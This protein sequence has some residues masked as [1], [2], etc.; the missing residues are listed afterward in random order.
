M[1]VANTKRD[2]ETMTL[3]IGP[4][5]LANCIKSR[6]R[7]R[8]ATALGDHLLAM[9]PIAGTPAVM[10]YGGDEDLFSTNAVEQ[11]KGIPGKHVSP[12][13]A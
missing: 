5:S 1:V 3:F 11:R 12:F 8:G 2:I 4:P 13:A 9:T 10:R 6:E 7:W